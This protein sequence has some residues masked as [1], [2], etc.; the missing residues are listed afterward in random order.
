MIQKLNNFGNS[1]RESLTIIAKAKTSK[2]ILIN[3]KCLSLAYLF[4]LK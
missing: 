4:N 3:I 2:I 1:E